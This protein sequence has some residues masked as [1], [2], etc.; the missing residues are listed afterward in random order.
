MIFGLGV[1]VVIGPMNGGM[2][3]PPHF[4]QRGAAERRYLLGL[5]RA[6]AEAMNRLMPG[7]RRAAFLLVANAA[8]RGRVAERI[9][10]EGR[11][12]GRE[13]RRSRALAVVGRRRS[14]RAGRQRSGH[15]RLSRSTGRLEGGRVADPGV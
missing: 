14:I 5:G 8:D 1:P 6:I 2:D 7:K 3:Y 12:A 11:A 9:G 4:R 13:R 15:L 10:P